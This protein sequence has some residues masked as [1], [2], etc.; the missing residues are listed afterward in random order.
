[1]HKQKKQSL[2]NINFVQDLTPE[3]A[4]A[5]SGGRVEAAV[6][7]D[8]SRIGFDPDVIFYTGRNLTGD[9]Y[10]VRATPGLGLKRLPSTGLAEFKNKSIPTNDNFESVEVIRGDWQVWVD[11]DFQGSS[12]RIRTPGKYNLSPTTRNEVSSLGRRG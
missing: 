9:G 12:G 5:Y 2:D 3:A 7:G 11:A 4:A 10:M 6:L 1:M 8:F